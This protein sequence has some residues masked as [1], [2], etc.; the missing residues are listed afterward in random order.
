MQPPPSSAIDAAF[1]ANLLDWWDPNQVAMLRSHACR[2]VEEGKAALSKSGGGSNANTGA[3]P[4]V[5]PQFVGAAWVALM[6]SRELVDATA[7][8]RQH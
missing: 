6:A 5:E 2:W 8:Q 7:R 4:P 3:R 1:A